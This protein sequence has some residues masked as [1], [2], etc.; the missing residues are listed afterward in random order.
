MSAA[1][2][3]GGV[4]AL[5]EAVRAGRET[6]RGLVERALAR[7]DAVDGD[8]KAWLAIEAEAA[9]AAADALGAEAASGRL[10]GPLH[11]LP[12]AVKDV[13]D[14]AGLPT[15]AYSRSRADAAPAR[16]DA[17][18]VSRLRAAGAIMLGKVHT[19]EFAYFEAVPPTRNP[20]DFSRTPGGSSGGSAAAVASGT[21]PCALGTQTAGSVNR[22]AAFCGVGA[23]KPSTLAVGGAG[24]TH[25]APSFDTVGAFATTAADAAMVAVAFAPEALRMDAAEPVAPA[26]LDVALI[27]DPLIAEKTEPSMIAAVA[28]FGE[29]IAASGAR[30]RRM[31]APVPLGELLAAH[32]TVLLAELG[33]VHAGL[34]EREDLIAPRLAEDIRKGL[35]IPDADHVEAL[36]ALI[37]MRRRFWSK[38]PWPALVLLPAAPGAAPVGEATGD[39]SFVSPMTAL[40]GPVASI[41]C[42]AAD[43]APLGA[44]LG[45]APAEDARLAAAL[46]ALDL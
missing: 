19:T 15:R 17:T 22:P 24:V 30:V 5:A 4:R 28:A 33:R 35:S 18:V 21:V 45:A 34:L 31:T 3:F 20:H 10:R 25:L 32:R 6:P 43:G 41:P 12:F 16:M 27:E 1:A 23:F 46:A 8:V 44:M 40:A 11:G 42:G 7:I 38:L 9:L 39:P 14:V 37:E 26:D 2:S 29:R 13:I 36:A